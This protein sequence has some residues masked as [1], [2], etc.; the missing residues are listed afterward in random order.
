MFRN[1]QQ[2]ISDDISTWSAFNAELICQCGKFVQEISKSEIDEELH[3]IAPPVSMASVDNDSDTSRP[4]TS[5]IPAWFTLQCFFEF[6]PIK[7]TRISVLP[8]IPHSPTIQTVQLEFLQQVEQV[9]HQLSGTSTKFVL[10]LDLGLYKPVQQLIMSRPE[11]QNR[12][13]IRPGEL[14]IFFAAIRAIGSFIDGTGSHRIKRVPT[15]CQMAPTGA[16][17]V[18]WHP[19]QQS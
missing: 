2:N 4:N 9:T 3:D 12:W 7:V 15:G 11:L 16:T 1:W 5:S 8:I 17:Y 18:V 6:E 10:T 13:I 19:K 14:H